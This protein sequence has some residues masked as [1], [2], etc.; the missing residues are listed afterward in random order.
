MVTPGGAAAKKQAKNESDDVEMKNIDSGLSSPIDVHST[1]GNSEKVLDLDSLTLED[2]KE[3]ARQIEKS[4]SSKEP[5]FVL[6]VFRSLA[7]TR[8]RINSRV[9]RKLINGFYTHSASQRDSLLA[10]IDEPMETDSSALVFKAR[11]T[12]T[13]HL[14]LLPELDV[15]F[16]LLVLLYLIDLQRFE[17][18]FTTFILLFIHFFYYCFAFNS[19]DS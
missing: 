18:V 13:S 4:V 15:Y 17:N 12:K 7:A 8:K 10:F 6:R 3:H 11:G 9:M 5:R 1:E 16:H 19:L 14:P 2:L